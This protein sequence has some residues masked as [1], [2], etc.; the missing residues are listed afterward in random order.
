MLFRKG[1]GGGASTAAFVALITLFIIIWILFLPPAERAKIL[2][3][4]S[5]SAALE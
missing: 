3:N 5:T 1:Q 4:E 2:D